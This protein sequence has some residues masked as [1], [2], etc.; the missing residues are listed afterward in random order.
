MAVAS[1]ITDFFQALPSSRYKSLTNCTHGRDNPLGEF[2]SSR[3]R[4]SSKTQRQPVDRPH[5]G[6]RIST[7]NSS[8]CK[9]EVWL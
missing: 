9:Y 8:R 7:R 5:A 6:P 3:P 2:W 1:S 4:Q